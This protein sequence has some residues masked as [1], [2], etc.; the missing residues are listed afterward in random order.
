MLGGGISDFNNYTP[1]RKLF[2]RNFIRFMG[3]LRLYMPD[4]QR[5]TSQTSWSKELLVLNRRIDFVC[6]SCC[7]LNRP[8]VRPA[9]RREL[10]DFFTSKLEVFLLLIP[11]QEK[12]RRNQRA[13][14]EHWSKRLCRSKAGIEEQRGLIGTGH[15]AHTKVQAPEGKFSH[16]G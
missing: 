3:M 11:K 7:Q 2:S 8:G 4:T 13:R 10:G 6:N 5:V 1:L 16:A 12:I 15:W 9:A 14:K